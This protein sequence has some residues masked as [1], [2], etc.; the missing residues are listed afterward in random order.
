MNLNKKMKEKKK[1]KKKVNTSPVTW[2]STSLS[3]TLTLYTIYPV[4]D[5]NDMLT[6]III[7]NSRKIILNGKTGENIYK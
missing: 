7:I 2:L 1:K 5:N 6:S 4:I 3:Q